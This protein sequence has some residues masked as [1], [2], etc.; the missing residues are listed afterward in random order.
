VYGSTR[1]LKT[2]PCDIIIDLYNNYNFSTVISSQNG[3]CDSGIPD[4]IIC[5]AAASLIKNVYL[6][7]CKSNGAPLIVKANI[8]THM[9]FRLINEISGMNHITLQ[10][11]GNTLI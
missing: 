6:E 3:R 5:R 8:I 1:R 7:A 4:M 2:L 11:M 9:R 10:L